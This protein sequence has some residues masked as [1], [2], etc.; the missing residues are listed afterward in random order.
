MEEYFD[1]EDHVIVTNPLDEK[2]VWRVGGEREYEIEPGQVKRLHGSAAR[3]Y[4]KKMCDMIL[5]RANRVQELHSLEARKEVADDLIVRVIRD[6]EELESEVLESDEEKAKKNDTAPAK[7]AETAFPEVKKQEPTV[8]LEA[9][10]KKAVEDVE[11]TKPSKPATKA[12]PTK[13]IPTSK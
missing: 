9:K 2:F 3:L 11:T 5:I 8:M 10:P 12:K 6:D 1:I 13:D 4:I 7:E